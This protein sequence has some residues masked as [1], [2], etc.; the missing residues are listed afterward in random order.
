[1][2]VVKDLI[3]KFSQSGEEREGKTLHRGSTGEYRGFDR[4]LTKNFKPLNIA[5]NGY[6]EVYYSKKDLC[7]VTS[8]EGDITI[9][10]YD[11]EAALK[12]DYENDKEFYMGG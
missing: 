12:T 5:F 11:N 9:I 10:V 3:E 7:S 2:T 6:R 8:C 1:M 4:H